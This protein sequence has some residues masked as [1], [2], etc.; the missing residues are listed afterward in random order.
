[1]LTRADLR[2]K[3][4]LFKTTQP[5]KTE[6]GVEEMMGTGQYY[7]HVLEEI[8]GTAPWRANG[9]GWSC[10]IWPKKSKKTQRNNGK[11]GRRGGGD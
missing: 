6:T 4:L 1:L 9:I 2:K 3:K 8:G 11:I 7:W 10:C 5:S